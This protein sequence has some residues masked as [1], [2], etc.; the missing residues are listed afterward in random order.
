MEKLVNEKIKKPT[1]FQ[2]GVFVRENA[3]FFITAGKPL[4][5]GLSRNGLIF[6]IN[7]SRPQLFRKA[8]TKF[9][10]KLV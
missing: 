7:F 6:F 4:L 5:S 1:S 9:T 8:F 2:L 10:P 3:E